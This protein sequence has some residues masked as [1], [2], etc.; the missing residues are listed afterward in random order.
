MRAVCGEPAVTAA[1]FQGDAASRRTKDLSAGPS[2][3]LLP[4][5]PSQCRALR[6]CSASPSRIKCH[7]SR[8]CHFSGAEPIHIPAKQNHSQLFRQRPRKVH[9]GSGAGRQVSQSGKPHLR[10]SL[11]SLNLPAGRCPLG[12]PGREFHPCIRNTQKISLRFERSTGP[13]SLELIFSAKGL[14]ALCTPRQRRRPCIP[15]K[16]LYP[17]GIPA[18]PWQKFSTDPAESFSLPEH[19]KTSFPLPLMNHV[20]GLMAMS[21]KKNPTRHRNRAVTVRMTDEEFLAM[22]EKVE[23]S[24]LSQQTYII[25]AVTGTPI[26][27]AD[28]MEELLSEWKDNSKDLSDLSRQLRGLGT[29]VNQMACI[30]NEYGDLPSEQYLHRISENVDQAKKGVDQIWRSIRSLISQQSHMGR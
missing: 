3:F 15:P 27:P 24:G 1:Y 21:N 11:R 22:R 18:A 5:H 20:K 16:G 28:G 9:K 26:L 12:S 13:S 17:F 29:N 10:R 6:K 4:G 25:E 23:E 14:L 2:L 8:T 7:V 19:I 30:A